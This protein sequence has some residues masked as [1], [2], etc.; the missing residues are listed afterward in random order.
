MSSK[1]K[2]FLAGQASRLARIPYHDLHYWD[3]SGFVKPSLSEA[4]KHSRYSFRD[5]VAL[6]VAASLRDKGASLK[7]MRLMVNRLQ[8]WEDLEEPIAQARLAVLNDDVVLVRSDT[9]VLS[10]LQRPG[11]FYVMAL[12][13]VSSVVA[14][15][16]SE[17]KESAA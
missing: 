16:Q 17:L 6:R 1:K 5:I 8:A 15:L 4:G 2:G 9:E 14:D 7:S 10:L 11:T 3:K 13:D 12:V